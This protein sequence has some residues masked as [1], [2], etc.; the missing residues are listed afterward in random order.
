M[1]ITELIWWLYTAFVLIMAVFFIV[2]AWLVKEKGG[3]D[4]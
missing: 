2:F 1:Y 3:R 4:G